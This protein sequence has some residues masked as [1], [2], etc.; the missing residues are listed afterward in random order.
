MNLLPLVPSAHPSARLA[1][2]VG[3]ERQGLCQH[4][5]RRDH[6]TCQFCGLPAGG[7]QDVFHLD[8]DHDNWTPANL[9]ASCPLCHAVQHIG[10]PTANQ[11][12]HVIWLPDVEQSLLN[13]LVR[14]IHTIMHGQGVPTTLTA[15]HM[16]ND[17]A[18]EAAWRAYAAL[19]A[20]RDAANR[21]IDSHHPLDVAD[22]LAAMSPQDYAR[23]ARFL[24]GLRLLHRGQILRQ[25]RDLYPA[26]LTLWAARANARPS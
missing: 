24:G 4:T 1:E 2:A 15:R 22:A 19:D 12:M 7:W 10:S 6:H 9:A 11:D 5:L 18:L 3:A 23:R 8:D 25:G 20:R 16:P 26:Q 13:V 21:I 17:A 14:G